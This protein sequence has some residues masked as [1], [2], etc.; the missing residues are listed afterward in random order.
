MRQ[1]HHPP[2]PSG[3]TLVEAIVVM[4]IT[5]ILVAGVALFLRKPVDAYFDLARRSELSD[6]T[7]TVARRVERDLRLAL[8]NSVRTVTTDEHC[9]EFLPI[10]NSA[11]YRADVGSPLPGNVFDTAAPLGAIDVLGPL[12]AAPAVGDLMVV[13]NLGIPG[14]D[15]YN[16]DNTGIV[17]AN[18]TTSLINLNPPKQFPF[19]SPGNRFMLLSGSE[20]AVFY[21]CTAPGIDA[22]GNGTGTLYRLSAYGINAS[23]PAACPS[24]PAGTPI[25]AQNLSTCD[26]SYGSGIAVRDGL[27]SIRLGVTKNNETVNLYQDVHVSNAP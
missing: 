14:A 3:F 19:A 5:G 26:F 22:A 13:Y 10:M 7:D 8:P 27:V 4:S 6:I 12:S 25:M 15:A 1:R 18:S 23:A 21:A 20:Q 9:L 16:G 17:A 2:R 11:T 24:V